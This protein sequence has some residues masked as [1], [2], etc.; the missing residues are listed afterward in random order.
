MAAATKEGALPYGRVTSFVTARPHWLTIVLGELLH[1]CSSIKC[2]LWPLMQRFFYLGNRAVGGYGFATS[3]FGSNPALAVAPPATKSLSRSK[4]QQQPRPVIQLE[5]DASDSDSDSST[6]SESSGNDRPHDAF[7]GQ[8][9]LSSSRASQVVNNLS[10]S[11][12]N[13]MALLRCQIN[14]GFIT[15]LFRD[16][17]FQSFIR[18]TCTL[19]VEVFL[20]DGVRSNCAMCEATWTAKH[21]FSLAN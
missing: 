17:V 11:S 13:R 15:I 3:S 1:S 8:D 4:Q 14:G 20:F 18:V 2:I 21:S 16:T 6:E 9:H 10:N 19:P 12:S 7:G 5:V